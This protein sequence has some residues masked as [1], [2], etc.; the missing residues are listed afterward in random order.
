MIDLIKLIK[1]KFEIKL[2]AGLPQDWCS[3]V[4]INFRWGQ[5]RK[6]YNIE[7]KSQNT[8]HIGSPTLEIICEL[9]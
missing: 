4:W 2:L 5:T 6:I 9:A 1:I 3:V 7:T 8:L